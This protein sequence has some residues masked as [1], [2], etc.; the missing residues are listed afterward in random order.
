MNA[1]YY[2]NWRNKMKTHLIMPMGGAGSRF[3]ENGFMVPK[4][5][6]EIEGRPFFYWA[7][8]SI[9]KFTDLEDIT[10]VV[11]QD[12]VDRF[13]LDTLI[14]K[15]YP[16]ANIVIIPEV[17]PGPVFTCLEGLK[18]INDEKPIIFNDCDHMFKCTSLYK[19][20]NGSGISADGALVTFESDVP[21]FSFVKYND[22]NE[23]VGTVEKEAVSNHAICGAYY[24]SSSQLFTDLADEY[25]KNCPYNET[26][27]SGM[28]N[29]MCG[30][31]MLVK[32]C[33][34]DFH[35]EFGTPEEYENAKGSMYFKD[36]L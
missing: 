10:Y 9:E 20:I 36:L 32:D 30:K 19:L 1:Y 13:F 27:L 25:I 17:T 28:Y 15:Y 34:L 6:I 21:H 12:H 2:R 23:V 24:F 22:N 16:N 18:V 3:H 14:R 33:L 8:R 4:P 35:V 26:F 7:T 31:G 11:L 5:I 29:I